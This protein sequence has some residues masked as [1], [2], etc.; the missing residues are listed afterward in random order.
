MGLIELWYNKL[1]HPHT[2][3][4]LT[5]TDDWLKVFY[6][7]LVLVDKKICL[8]IQNKDYINHVLFYNDFKGSTILRFRDC[9]ESMGLKVK[10]NFYGSRHGGGVVFTIFL[11]GV[12]RLN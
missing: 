10:S 3:K 6:K 4:Y 2:F 12:W 1:F 8:N 7:D 11:D 9:L 5:P